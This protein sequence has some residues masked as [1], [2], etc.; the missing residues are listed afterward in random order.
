M[1][2]CIHDRCG[3]VHDIHELIARYIPRSASR[4][5]PAPP[6]HPLQ[7]LQLL[8]AKSR[9]CPPHPHRIDRTNRWREPPNARGSSAH[10]PHWRQDPAPYS[11][12]F[13]PTNPLGHH[14]GWAT[15]R[16]PFPL[17]AMPTGLESP[18]A[19]L[20][21][22]TETASG[23][24]D[25]PSQCRGERIRRRA[26]VSLSPAVLWRPLRRRNPSCRDDCDAMYLMYM[27]DNM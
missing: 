26:L 4:P 10:T 20:K 13:A 11:S 22:H 15:T 8:G 17:L 16:E 27:C 14:E 12:S 3:L 7:S 18:T 24:L 23:E 2:Q 25:V 6:A 19:R 5:S 21:N 1:Y 9:Q